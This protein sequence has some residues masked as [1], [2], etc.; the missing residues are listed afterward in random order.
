MGRDVLAAR[1]R[2][3]PQKVTRFTATASLPPRAQ[4]LSPASSVGCRPKT[5]NDRE[6]Q[7]TME[8]SAAMPSG[9]R[10]ETALSPLS[11]FRVAPK[12]KRASSLP[13]KRTS[14]SAASVLTAAPPPS[15]RTPF[16]SVSRSP[17][18]HR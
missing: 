13:P 12:R 6:D 11:R 4:W 17:P 3:T 15:T 9:R 18:R 7:P 8:N 16:L 2:Q 1:A 14:Y 5:G 10:T